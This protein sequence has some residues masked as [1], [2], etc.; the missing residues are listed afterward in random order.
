VFIVPKPNDERPCIVDSVIP[1]LFTEPLL[2]N[3]HMNN[4]MLCEDA[5][6]FISIPLDF[7][8]VKVKR[9]ITSDLRG[10][11]PNFSFFS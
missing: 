6:N 5:C 1:G 11:S 4:N 3:G 8:D 9:R 2:S 7:Y 10:Q